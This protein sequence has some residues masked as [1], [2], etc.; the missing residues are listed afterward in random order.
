MFNP[1]T[2]FRT[3]I[4]I[5][6]CRCVFMFNK[7]RWSIVV[8]CVEVGEIYFNITVKPFVFHNFTQI[9]RTRTELCLIKNK[10]NF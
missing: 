10:S 3:W 5:G 6:M 2:F 4:S 1:A 8:R 9:L 7:E